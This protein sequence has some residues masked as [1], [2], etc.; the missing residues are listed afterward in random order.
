MCERF[1]LPSFGSCAATL[2]TPPATNDKQIRAHLRQ[3]LF[4]KYWNDPDTM[5]LEELGLRHGYCR[6]DLAVVNGSLHGF[7]IKSDR[8][9]FRRLAR[10]AETYNKVLDFVTIVVGE[11]HAERALNVSPQWWG[12]QFA[13]RDGREEVRLI[14]VREPTEN[15]GPDK[16]AIAKLLWREE[17]LTFLEELGGADG[18]RSKPRRLV[19][20]RLAELASLDAIRL[21]VR[22]RLRSR[23]G[24]R[25]DGSRRSGDD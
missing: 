7:E 3:L 14:E 18:L 16:L 24:W 8:D 9:T 4:R 21:Y 2:K 19:Y 5:I 15:P 22:S 6:I 1:A 12:I 13:K 25:S 20:C 10:Q 11:R 17:A 23:K